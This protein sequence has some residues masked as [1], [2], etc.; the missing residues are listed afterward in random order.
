M[1]A[2]YRFLLGASALAFLLNQQAFG[3]NPAFEQRRS[4][5]INTALSNFS[6]DA[7]TLQAYSGAPLDLA[8]LNNLINHISTNGVADFDIVK[9][10]RI[11]FFT[12]GAYDTLILPALNSIPYWVTKGDTLRGYWSENH[13][14]QWMSSDWL[15][16]ER[17]GRSIDA[18]LDHRLRHYLR[19]KV[20]YGFYEFFSSVYAPYCLT[21][22][23]NLAD[24]AQ[25]VEIK[26]LATRAS[27]Q[28]LKDLLMI[29]ND[30]GVFFP[31]AGR[32]Y[33][34]KYETPYGEN[35][36]NLIYLLTGFGQAPLSASHAG[37]FLASSSLPVDNVIASWTPDIDTLYHIGHS[38]DSGLVINSAL[39]PAGRVMFQW[40]SGAYFHPD[41]AEETAQFLVDSNLWHHIDFTAFRPFSGLSVPLIV[42][43]SNSLRAASES[44]VLSEASVAIFKRQS[45]TLSSIQ[46]FWKGK[47]GYQ[48]FPCVA[49][50]G[51]TAVFTAS[52]KI[53]L[54]WDARP[55]SNANEHLP[56]V[57]QKKNVALVMYRPEPYGIEGVLPFH[58]P[59]VAL[60]FNEPDFDEVK[61]DS[62]WLLGRQGG[63]YVA[64][65]RHCM[66]EI[67][68]VKACYMDDGQTWVIVVG[69]SGMYGS[70]NNFQSVI[71]QSEYEEKWYFDT[72]ASQTVYYAKI[73]VDTIAIEYAWGVDGSMG[74]GF[75]NTKIATGRFSVFPNPTHDN[76]TLDLSHFANQSLTI[77]VVNAT[78]QVVYHETGHNLNAP[79]Y[80]SIR[81]W[82]DGMYFIMVENQKSRFFNKI[83]VASP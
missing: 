41:V 28:L 47:V 34:G 76:L 75:E 11:L 21:G 25:D 52:G 80:I 61:N 72:L 46:N 8:V 63:S 30:K 69:D 23:L 31:A 43:L 57:C 45:I 9:L 36:N 17:Y 33:Y 26:D 81:G 66:G 71:G 58:N 7:I 78:G 39:S 13:M 56:Y 37:G 27:Q 60:H 22:L 5:Y 20:Q 59:E 49:N 32:N 73:M 67:D 53:E 70:F 55:E 2:Y 38:L 15:L 1:V 16:H 44:S 29:T 50:I 35:H 48:Q 24:F 3:G 19:L 54:P 6:S 68:S 74:T 42:S 77:N 12:N 4:D 83:F 51:T 82:A 10:V 62:M 40:S 64:V 14:I 18:T 79:K 65:R